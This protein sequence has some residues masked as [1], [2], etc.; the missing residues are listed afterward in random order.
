MSRGS[1][2][3]ANAPAAAVL[4][5]PERHVCRPARAGMKHR[6][7]QS[8]QSSRA[9]HSAKAFRVLLMF[10]THQDVVP[11]VLRLPSRRLSVTSPPGWY[12][13]ECVPNVMV[14]ADARH[15]SPR[16]RDHSAAVYAECL[17][18]EEKEMSATVQEV[19]RHP[20]LALVSR[21]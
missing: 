3:M 12:A 14:E 2:S 7:R 10:F 17:S 5:R 20:V 13:Y 8:A 4:I 21:H 18:Q 6:R 15:V 9:R 16:P 11:A 19:Q 1:G